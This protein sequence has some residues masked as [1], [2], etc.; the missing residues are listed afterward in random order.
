MTMDPYRRALVYVRS[1][2]AGVIEE[3]D[4]GYRFAYDGAYL[5]GENP[6]PVSLTLPVS[7]TE[8][9][10]KTFFPFFDGLIPEGWLLDVASRNWKI[11][12]SDR[13]GLMMLC[14]RDCIGD[15]SVVPYVEGQH[16][17]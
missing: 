6:L 7:E 8:Y 11:D 9:R 1:V 13:F 5:S 14:C 15:V 16:E 2:L 12:R 10:S 3:T 17:M 4:D